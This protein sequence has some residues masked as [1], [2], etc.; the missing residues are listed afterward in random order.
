MLLILFL[1][2]D[3][4]EIHFP[5]TFSEATVTLIPKPHK[6]STKKDYRQ[7]SAMNTDAKILNKILT[8]QIQEHIKKIVHQNQ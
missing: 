5:N 6:D 1:K 4:P 8:S 7:I 3:T 2:I